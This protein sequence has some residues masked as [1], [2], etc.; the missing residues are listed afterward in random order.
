ML[1]FV[2]MLEINSLK[3][4]KPTILY[5]RE[6]IWVAIKGYMTLHYYTRHSL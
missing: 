3:K 5:D 2:S 4:T 6:S 1:V